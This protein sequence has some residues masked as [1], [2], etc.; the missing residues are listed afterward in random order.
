MFRVNTVDKQ[1]LS[2]DPVQMLQ[3]VM[4]GKTSM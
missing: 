2:V 1:E 4:C 3:N